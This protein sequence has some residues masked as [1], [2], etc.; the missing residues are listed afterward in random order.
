MVT[1]DDHEVDNDYADDISEE[2]DVPEL[3]LARRAAAYQAYYE[4]LPLPRRA[5]PFGAS[6]RLYAS[7]AFGTLA[8]VV[9]LDE[10]QYRSPQ[11]CPRPGRRGANRVKDCAELWLP[12]RTKLGAQQER[13][14]EAQLAASK[15]LWNLTAEGTVIAYVDEQPG[16]GE[17]FWTDGWNGYPA[18]RQRLLESTLR[19]GAQNPVF[20]S[21]DIHAFL[22]ANLQREPTNPESAVVAT[23]FTTTSITSQARPQ[24][25]LDSRRQENP[26][27][28]WA[29]SERRGYVRLD[30]DRTR[31]LADFVAM[32][33]VTRPDAGRSIQ[34]SF[35][36]EAGQPGVKPG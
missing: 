30:M 6:M 15:A 1:W 23:E 35:V 27:V 28:L 7:R 29:N 2:D 34:A 11:A 17:Q 3:F 4:H 25:E 16:P 19:S 18:A 20:F 5:V 8:S 32:E 33:S 22:A 31:L 36:V 10:R 13:W 21:G 14:F 9:M 12:E 24:A 26:A